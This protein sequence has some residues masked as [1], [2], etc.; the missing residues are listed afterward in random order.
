MNTPISSVVEAAGNAGQAIRGVA[1]AVRARR[2]R[3]RVS[4]APGTPEA[5]PNA[6]GRFSLSGNGQTTVEYWRNRMAA[7]P[8]GTVRELQPVLDAH[9]MGGASSI[10]RRLAVTE[11]Q[12]A[13]PQGVQQ[14]L[15]RAFRNYRRNADGS[16]SGTAAGYNR[17]SKGAVTGRPEE[18]IRYTFIP[19]EVNGSVGRLILESNGVQTDDVHINLR[20][21]PV[22]AT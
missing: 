3:I 14:H 5:R 13:N 8:E 20:D 7:D 18:M 12:D 2:P 11:R 15:F 19:D 1:S 9:G 21:L 22:A 4:A 6:G 10:E 16:F 17:D